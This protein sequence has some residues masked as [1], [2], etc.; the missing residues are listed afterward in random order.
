MAFSLYAATIP[1]YLQILGAVGGLVAKAE[2][3]CA[4]T[5]VPPAELIEAQLAADMWPLATQVKSTVMHSVGAIEGVRKGV[6]APDPSAPRDSFAGL[7]TQ[8]ADAIAMLE[9]VSAAEVDGFVGRDMRFEF[10]DRRL[11]FT[12]EDFLLSFSQPNFYFHATT[13]YDILRFKGLR[14]EKRDFTGRVRL[15]R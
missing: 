1:S 3:H 10:R 14:L 9:K 11:D 6:F 12:A 2:A 5:G 7:K 4:Q 8:V 13:V 15:K